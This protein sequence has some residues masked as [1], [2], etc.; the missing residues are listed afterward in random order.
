MSH[1]VDGID[2]LVHG[3]SC[4]AMGKAPRPI[5]D[6][7]RVQG[8]KLVDTGVVFPDFAE[9][10][11]FGQGRVEMSDLMMQSDE[12]STKNFA[13]SV[14]IEARYFLASAKVQ[15]KYAHGQTSAHNSTISPRRLYLDF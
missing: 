4:G 11:P 15:S 1:A 10:V 13:L 12:A 7:T 6:D 2:S 8:K 3:F 5:F 9:C 14:G